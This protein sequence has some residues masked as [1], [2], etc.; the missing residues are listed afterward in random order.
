MCDAQYAVPQL[1]PIVRIRKSFGVLTEAQLSI[2]PTNLARPNQTMTEVLPPFIISTHTP[3]PQHQSKTTNLNVQALHSKPVVRFLRTLG[4]KQK[5]VSSNDSH[6]QLITTVPGEGWAIH[7]VNHLLLR[8]IKLFPPFVEQI[9]EL[10]IISSTLQVTT[11]TILS[12]QKLSPT[13]TLS[14]PCVAISLPHTS[15][16]SPQEAQSSTSAHKLVKSRVRYIYAPIS[17]SPAHSSGAVNEGRTVWIWI[18]DEVSGGHGERK[19]LEA[20]GEGP[21]NLIKE[22]ESRVKMVHVLPQCTEEL[23]QARGSTPHPDV[24]IVVLLEN[25]DIVLCDHELSVIATCRSSRNSKSSSTK[26]PKSSNDLLRIHTSDWAPVQVHSTTLSS[27]SS[28]RL[29][30]PSLTL[31]IAHA[32]SVLSTPHEETPQNSPLSHG[33]GKKRKSGPIAKPTSS[34]STSQVS[35]YS[36]LQIEAYEVALDRLQSVGDLTSEVDLLDVAIGAS[37][38]VTILGKWFTS[39]LVISF[40]SLTASPFVPPPPPPSSLCWCL[41]HRSRSDAQNTPS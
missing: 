6:L 28:A 18:E 19:K 37:G 32:Q 9:T 7:N 30:S 14:A 39:S 40:N 21:A 8:Y 17:S 10:R 13:L 4:N 3:N 41:Q 1:H 15:S 12:S 33:R 16:S 31:Y 29:P 11:Q 38:W 36:G 24:R 5:L 20:E 25:G 35:H 23:H 34:K 27:R 26:R 22:F 2:H